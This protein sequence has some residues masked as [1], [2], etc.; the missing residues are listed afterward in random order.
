MAPTFRMNKELIFDSPEYC[1]AAGVCGLEMLMDHPYRPFV[2]V[3]NDGKRVAY[4]ILDR[5]AI[6]ICETPEGE[7]SS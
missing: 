3:F 5:R 4:K 7:A 2:I 1:V 6:A